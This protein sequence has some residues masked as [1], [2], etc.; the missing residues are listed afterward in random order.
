MNV[1]GS[2]TLPLARKDRALARAMIYAAHR[3]PIYFRIRSNEPDDLEQVLDAR[4]YRPEADT[5]TLFMDFARTPPPAETDR[6]RWS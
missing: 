2:G 3:Q 1:I 5:L 4:G 6:H